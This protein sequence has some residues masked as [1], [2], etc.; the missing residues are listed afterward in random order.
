MPGDLFAPRFRKWAAGLFSVAMMAAVASPLLENWRSVPTDSFPLSYYPMF[1][2]ERGETAAVT[3]MV[4]IDATGARRPLHYRYAAGGGMNQ[5]RKRITNMVRNGKAGDLCRSV[6]ENVAMRSTR[7]L[8]TI[9]AIEIRTD[10][11]R[12][13]EYFETSNRVPVT[14]EVH[15]TCGV[16]QRRG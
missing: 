13:R 15:H 10:S 1:T 12:L 4:G 3:Y 14:E 6:A 9:V 2:S 11:Y 5:A 8:D 7:R 16:E